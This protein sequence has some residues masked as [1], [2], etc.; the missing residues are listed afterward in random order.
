MAISLDII[1]CTG[2]S[3]LLSK[4]SCP[5]QVTCQAP[6]AELHCCKLQCPRPACTAASCSTPTPACSQL[7]A[8]HPRLQQS[9]GLSV[10]PSSVVIAITSL[11]SRVYAIASPKPAALQPLSLFLCLRGYVIKTT[12]SRLHSSLVTESEK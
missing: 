2:C 3:T 1:N 7:L 12:S 9:A 10:L 6:G 5:R 8:S 4:G 11:C